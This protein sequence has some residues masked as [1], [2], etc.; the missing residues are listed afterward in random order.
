MSTFRRPD[1]LR[2]SLTQ[3]RQQTFRDFEVVISD[4]DPEGSAASVVQELQ[5]ARFKYYHNGDNL[6]MVRS[7]NK[8]IERATG[9][10]IVM[11]TDDDPV[12]PEMLQTLY[13][14]SLQYPGYGMY[15]GGHNT[16]FESLLEARMS[17]VKIGM[18][19]G[20]ADA[21]I[22][23]VKEFN[24]SVFP[25]KY[26]QTELAGQLLWSTGVVK[27]EIVL[28]VGGFGDFGTPHLADCA[29]VLLSGSRAGL[30]YINQALGHR[31]IHKENYS[32][33]NANY[34]SIYKAPEGFYRWV[35]DRLPTAGIDTGLQ[36]ALQHYV[37]RDLTV[38]VIFIK[39]MLDSTHQKNPV[40]E[41][42][43]R[44]FFKLPYLKRWRRKYFISTHFPR[45]FEFF[46]AVRKLMTPQ[47]KKMT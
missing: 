15:F 40:F 46:L 24:A 35:M 6:G 27:R 5:D 37:G 47:Y 45:S 4:N 9:Q 38:S 25:L 2:K 33:S 23:A 21:E 44:R 31:T 26:L 42:F 32:Y 22:G 28:E 36:N 29:Y 14:L 13:D 16:Y 12:Y 1:F 19:S 30:V 17:K 10:F 43:A 8:S 3:I 34:E 11:I 39:K 20:L 41:D 18:I 7:F